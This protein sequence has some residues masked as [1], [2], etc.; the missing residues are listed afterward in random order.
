MSELASENLI[1]SMLLVR[2]VHS[3][4]GMD[5][6]SCGKFSDSALH[7]Q[8]A[9]LIMGKLHSHDKHTRKRTSPSAEE[10]GDVNWY[11]VQIDKGERL[12]NDQMN[13]VK[14]S[15]DAKHERRYEPSTTNLYQNKQQ[16]FISIVV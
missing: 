6:I 11:S 9:W 8:D 3:I 5:I 2:L 12:T 15:Y 7:V 10:N 4:C 14:V 16:Q 1:L 13:Y